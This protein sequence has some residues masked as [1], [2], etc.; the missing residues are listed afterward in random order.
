MYTNMM[1]TRTYP[2]LKDEIME[3]QAKKIRAEIG[4]DKV[5]DDIN[6]IDFQIRQLKLKLNKLEGGK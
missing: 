2:E 4:L 1:D 5:V 3:L 6:D